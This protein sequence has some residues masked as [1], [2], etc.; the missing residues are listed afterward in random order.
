MNN[1]TSNY[2]PL[3][4]ILFNVFQYC[5]YLYIF[6]D[7]T[8]DIFGCKSMYINLFFEEPCDLLLSWL[9]GT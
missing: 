6:K 8:V 7:F 9:Y 1:V 3:L 2:W 4:I 5:N